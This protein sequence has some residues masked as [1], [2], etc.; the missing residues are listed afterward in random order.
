MRIMIIGAHPADTIDLAG[1]TIAQHGNDGDTIE[2]LSITDG[3]NS[4]TDSNEIGIVEKRYELNKAVSCLIE[5]PKANIKIINVQFMGLQDEPLIINSA[6]ILDLIERIRKFRPN[7]LVTHHPNE[8]AHWDHAEVGKMVCRALKGAMKRS[9]DKWWVSNVYF[10]ATQFRPEVARL[11]IVPL[12]PT[13]LIDIS[14]MIEKKVK[15]LSCFKS[16]GHTKEQ[17][18]LRI[19][20]MEREMGRADGLDYSEGF[21]S[22]YPMKDKFLQMSKIDKSFYVKEK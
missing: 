10:F 17:M 2:I 11:G 14:E 16:Q 19:N 4:H 18:W 12:S 6:C 22:Y 3:L 20:S 9:G 15:A 21:I 13:I 7:I 5:K 8:Y 1:G